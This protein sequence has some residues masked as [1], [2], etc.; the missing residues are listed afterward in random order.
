MSSRCDRAGKATYQAFS[1][2]T[3]RMN[4]EIGHMRFKLRTL[5]VLPLLTGMVIYSCEHFSSFK[6]QHGHYREIVLA[7][8]V[9][10]PI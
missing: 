5:L 1:L 4:T 6:V 9:F 3:D 2:S 10:A 7:C 8:V